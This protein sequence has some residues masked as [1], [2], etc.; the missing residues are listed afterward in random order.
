M[1]TK[2]CHTCGSMARP[3]KVH[4]QNCMDKMIAKARAKRAQ[5]YCVDC[6]RVK[7]EGGKS[8]C[9]SCTQKRRGYDKRAREARIA[10]GLCAECGKQH[11][12]STKLCARCK[13]S[14]LAKQYKKNFGGVRGEILERDSGLCKCCGKLGRDVHHIDNSGKDRIGQKLRDDINN[15][16][17][18]L[19]LLCRRCH[20]DIHRLGNGGTRHIAAALIMYI[21]AQNNT[22]KRATTKGWIPIRK[23]IRKRDNNACVLCAEAEKTLVV[24]H[25]DGQGLF[26]ETPNNADSNLITLCRSCHNAVTNLRNNASR[27]LASKL[28]YA[29]GPGTVG[30]PASQ[31]SV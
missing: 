15:N 10:A 1:S 24:H 7:P 19:I 27:Q 16:P 2:K 23:R 26:S 22:R 14:A 5:G 29:L 28:V 3:G 31:Q 17:S 21:G 9:K 4:C 13:K 6:R 11:S 30:R 20:T 18:N 12:E 8:R 25:K